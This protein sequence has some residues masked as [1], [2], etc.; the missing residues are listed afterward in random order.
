MAEENYLRW[1]VGN[2]ATTWWND[3]GDPDE[4]RESLTHGA[5][6]VTTNPVLSYRALVSRAQEWSPT[7][8]GL[9]HTYTGEERAEA[10]IKL[11]VTGAAQL[12]EPV[13]QSTGGKQGYVCGQVN[14]KRAGD[15]E[16]MLAMARR[17]HAW[18]PNI[19]VKLPATAAGLDVMEE[20]A[21]EGITV[22]MTVSFTVPQALAIGE[23]FEK[24]RARAEKAGITPGR[25]FAVIMIGR[26]DDYLREV[27]Q[28]MQANVSEA[29]IRQAGLAATKRA[30]QIYKERDYQA[31]LLIAALRGTY[32]TTELA[33]AEVIMSITP[34]NQQQL[35]ASGVPREQRIDKPIAPDVIA[36]LQ[37]IP[38][39]VRAY[40]PDGMAPSEFVSYGVTQRTLSQF[41]E[42]GWS[43]LES[44]KLG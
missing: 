15:R 31:V 26:L 36:R 43:M 5:T 22:T 37:T 41:T 3:S 39:F 24:G 12:L 20:C 21:A 14:P 34:G 17:Y 16:G 4:I 44:F 9:I 19:A 8:G 23:R 11:V 27:A 1:L 18:A 7:I 40:E 33:G 38:E 32:H 25:C 35:F 2:T 42:V 28:D 30:Y 6:G 29:D 13:Y 10:L